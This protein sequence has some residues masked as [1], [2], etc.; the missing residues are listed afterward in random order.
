M[1]DEDKVMAKLV[2]IDGR[3]VESLGS[4]DKRLSKLEETTEQ[5]RTDVSE[6]RMVNA[7]QTAE[8]AIHCDRLN[9][10][11]G[12]QWAFGAGNGILAALAMVLGLKG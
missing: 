10:V 3:L 12:R 11:E 1:S 9:K 4:I 8:L 6:I 7:L 5:V 2:L